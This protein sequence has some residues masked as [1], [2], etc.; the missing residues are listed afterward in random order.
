MPTMIRP[1][2]KGK[3]IAFK[4]IGKP[5]NLAYKKTKKQ[6]ELDMILTFQETNRAK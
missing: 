1:K 5:A 6:K 4:I 2:G 3:D